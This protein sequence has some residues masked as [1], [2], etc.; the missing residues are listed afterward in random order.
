MP[1]TSASVSNSSISSND[2]RTRT[3]RV[4]EIQGELRS[5]LAL[6]VALPTRGA[7]L[8]T[9]PFVR[10]VRD[11]VLAVARHTV[12][13][14]FLL[15]SRRQR[16]PEE[17]LC[18]VAVTGPADVGD[19]VYRGRSG[20][21]VAM[22][23]IAGRRPA[24]VVL[25][26]QGLAVHALHILFVLIRLD[27]EVAHVLGVRVAVPARPWNVGCVNRRLGVVDFAH[28]MRAVAARALSH[29]SLALG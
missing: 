29:S 3:E 21:V 13:E 24:H 6:F 7:G 4:G 14:R 9:L 25:L 8:V 12:G 20:T 10:D 22:A 23:I 28:P 1:F 26:E 17:E 15:E 18:V 2:C 5:L 16:A 27:V 19:R 11:E